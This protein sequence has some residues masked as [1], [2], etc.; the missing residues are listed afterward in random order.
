MSIYSVNTYQL[1]NSFYVRNDGD[2]YYV[3]DTNLIYTY[4]ATAAS[5]STDYVIRASNAGELPEV[6]SA[7]LLVNNGDYDAANSIA[8]GLDTLIE[9]DDTTDTGDL[10]QYLGDYTGDLPY[11]EAREVS[12]IGWGLAD[13]YAETPAELS[14][15]LEDILLT[16][17]TYSDLRNWDVKIEVSPIDHILDLPN[18]LPNISTLTA[19]DVGDIYYVVET[20]NT[21]NYALTQLAWHSPIYVTDTNKVYTYDSGSWTTEDVVYAE[22]SQEWY[23]VDTATNLPSDPVAWIQ[24]DAFG[25][26]NQN[27]Y[28]VLQYQ[29]DG[30]YYEPTLDP[31]LQAEENK[32]VNKSLSKLPAPYLSGLK[33][34]EDIEIN[35]LV[36]NKIEYPSDSNG[37]IDPVVWVATDIEGWWE[38]PDS[39]M[40]DLTRGWGDGS[41]DARGR[42]NARVLTLTGSA[43][44][45]S[46]AD[47]AAVRDRLLRATALVHTGGWLKVNEEPTKASYVRSSG[48]ANIGSKNPRGR[49]DFSIGLKAA[50]PIKYEWAEGS[51][52]GYSYVDI[53]SSDTDTVTITNN[54]NIAVPVVFE[55]RNGLTSASSSEPA[56][57]TNLTPD[58]PEIIEIVDTVGSTQTLEID[59]YN[60]EV[61][62][63]NSSGVATS[64]RSKTETL[65]T[66]IYLQPGDNE[67]QFFDSAD[68]SSEA[69][70][71]VYYR[72]GWIG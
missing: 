27:L 29:L 17:L 61:L 19:E 48:K 39:E 14:S 43:L 33:L 9:L 55:I 68:H 58:V 35:G 52:D 71:R 15:P 67:L 66:W 16:S 1:R 7:D 44:V 70:C 69:I 60:R 8:V 12:F 42:Y 50:D 51:E 56:I 64:G 53:P 11:G 2:K 5:W 28:A 57:I 38:S 25:P 54:G 32:I 37:Y 31:A 40:P 10:L 36:L 49:I 41:Y 21:D 20:S 24:I 6:A 26:Y 4:D 63:V 65:L 45:Q 59:T 18:T 23:E 30:T 62:L 13:T 72:S 46:P 3:T 34:Q 22:N 47:S